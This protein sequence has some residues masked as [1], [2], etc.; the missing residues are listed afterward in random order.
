MATVVTPRSWEER[1]AEAAT[2]TGLVRLVARAYRASDVVEADAIIVG[3]ETPWLSTR[4]IAAWRRRGVVVIGI[5]PRGDRPAVELL[6]RAGVDQ[7]FM[8]G[9]DPLLILRAARELVAAATAELAPP[10]TPSQTAL[11]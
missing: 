1:L 8:E 9:T 11:P 6:C 2:E 5:F 7:L 3:T 10:A 4:L